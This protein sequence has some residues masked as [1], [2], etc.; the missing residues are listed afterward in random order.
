MAKKKE[1]HRRLWTKS[2]LRDLKRHSRKRTPLDEIVKDMQR[3]V[4]ALRWKACQMGFGLGQT[5]RQG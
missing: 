5:Q 1:N 4:G 3:T 2:D